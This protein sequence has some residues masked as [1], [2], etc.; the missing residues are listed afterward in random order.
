MI[1]NVI[2]GE[3]EFSAKNP[4]YALQA[5]RQAPQLQKHIQVMP[6]D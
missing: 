3:A 4:D 1:G 6:R 5:C 2:Q